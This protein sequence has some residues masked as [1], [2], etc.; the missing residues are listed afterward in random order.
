VNDF[1]HGGGL[2]GNP[3]LVHPLWLVWFVVKNKKTHNMRRPEVSASG[4]MTVRRQ[5]PKVVVAKKKKP[6]V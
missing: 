6:T 3:H 2:K 1:A 4:W 5:Y